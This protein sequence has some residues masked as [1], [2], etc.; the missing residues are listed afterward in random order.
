LRRSPSFTEFSKSISSFPA[1]RPRFHRSSPAV[2][3]PKIIC[4]N[5]FVV[6]L[7][8][9]GANAIP[10]AMNELVDWLMEML[11]SNGAEAVVTADVAEIEFVW[12]NRRWRLIVG[13]WREGE[14]LRNFVI[15][16]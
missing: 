7:K 13:E 12:N 11:R 5:P 15:G 8:S 4:V 9:F 6:E 16:G 1:L 3:E 10:F 2:A 14:G